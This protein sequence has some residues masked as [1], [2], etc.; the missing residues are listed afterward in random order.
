MGGRREG[1][2]LR[3]LPSVQRLVAAA[4]ATPGE[5]AARAAARALL[6]EERG[7]LRAGEAPRGPEALAAALIL[8]LGQGARRP[9]R[10]R[11]V[12]NAT[13]VILHT[14]LG[15][16]PLHPDAQAALARVGA[17]YCNAE[18][19]LETG[20]RGGRLE[21]VAT[22]LRALVGAPAALAV[23]NGAAAVLLALTAL[24]RGREVVVSR[25]ELVEIG[26]SFRVPEVISE[27][28]A[29]LVEVGAT[30]RTRARD[31]AAAVGPQTG[32]LLRVHPS[33]FHMSG[34][35]ARPA[36]PALVEVA[37]AA[38]LP[39][40]EDLG[41]GRVGRAH[42]PRDEDDVARAILEGAD[43]VCFSGD[44]LLG[45]PQAG[46]I[47]G[48]PALVEACARHP[49][50]R[51]LR[52]DKLRLAALEA[53]LEVHLR[54]EEVP[55]AALAGRPAAELR[56]VVQE[57]AARLGPAAAAAGLQLAVEEDLAPVGGGAGADG[58]LPGPVLCLR[59]PGLEALAAA[60]RCGE[61][62]V[63]TR[64]QRGALRVDPRALLAGEAGPLFTALEAALAA[65]AAH[66]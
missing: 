4:G 40:I 19:V 51:A 33:N 41:G 37:R 43:L 3:G 60:L 35:V 42:E 28:G 16:A 8:Q 11:R 45:G 13:G 58:A 64:T 38:G 20:L 63:L 23:N 29:R 18:L 12:I 1:A 54:G 2:E 46:I 66:G 21:G 62:A 32:A 7:R 14:N 53:T 15:R 55:V 31:Y 22:P 59:G 57:L 61:P 5:G 49:L 44:K 39:L 47:A 34:F 24:C 10:L 9:P 56:A 17:G 25:G 27:G 50:Y 36:R 26:G 6:D 65:Q 48:A 52:V 30:N